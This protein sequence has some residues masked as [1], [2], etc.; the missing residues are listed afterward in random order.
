MALGVISKKKNPT[1]SATRN[2][3]LL[4]SSEQTPSFTEL[5]LLM[6]NIHY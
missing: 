5:S 4:P 2:E 1:G 6:R 3:S